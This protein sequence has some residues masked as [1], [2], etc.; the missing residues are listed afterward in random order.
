MRFASKLGNMDIFQWIVY[1]GQYLRQT[2]R[3]ELGLTQNELMTKLNLA[4]EEF[5]S[6]DVVTL[7]PLGKKDQ[8]DTI[9]KWCA[10]LRCLKTDLAD[11]CVTPK[12]ELRTLVY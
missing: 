11:F 8:T 2:K 7:V 5:L 1:V 9:P 6:L 3:E 12:S 10:T 4:D